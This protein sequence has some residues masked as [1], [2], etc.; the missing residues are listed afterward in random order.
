M[1]EKNSIS[2]RHF[3]FL[4]LGAVALLVIFGITMIRS[5]VAGN[6]ELEELDVV[7]RQIIFAVGGFVVVLV[8]ASIDYRLWA[9]ISRTLYLGTAGLLA[10]L[11]VVGAALFGSARWFD[12]GVIL[13]QPSE[14][15]KIVLILV[16]AD[17]FTRNQENL[18]SIRVVIRSLIMAM[19]IVIW[20]ILQPNL[21][22]SIVMVVIWFALLWAAGLRVRHLVT[23]GGSA[24]LIL[25]L[26]TP[27]LISADIIK[28]YQLDRVTN[29]LFPDETASYG[30][31]YNIQQAL[32]SIGSG[33]W[34][35]QGYGHGSQVQLRFL[36][37]RTSDFIY[38]AMAEEFGFIGTILVTLVLLFVI[39]RCMR[40]AHLSQ[41]TFGAL[42][43]YGVATLLTFQAMVN[44]G[45]NL[46]LMPATG[47]TFPF[48][49]YGGSSLLSSLI[50]I[51][52]VESVI[53]RHR[54]LEF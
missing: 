10:I 11:T 39:Y 22:T 6:I 34:F 16:L 14:L 29:F 13:I 46:N 38:S 41:D 37:V 5:A 48:V 19:G 12:T 27:I 40:A 52:L 43:C 33:G 20:V 51:G 7:T 1:N 44:I 3:D 4:L 49:S 2:W 24:V 9:S 54:S 31:S 28:E 17:F 21:S 35:G 30:E 8:V 25:A 32:I 47:L 50:G 45:V 23:V 15:A 18:G 42:I 53:L 36:K 26:L